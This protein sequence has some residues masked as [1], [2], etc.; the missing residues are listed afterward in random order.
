MSHR[1]DAML[2]RIAQSAQRHFRHGCWLEVQPLS[3][4]QDDATVTEYPEQSRALRAGDSL[5]VQSLRDGQPVMMRNDQNPLALRRRSDA[6][7]WITAELPLA[8]ER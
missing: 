1:T 3:I 2:L 7:G 5:R 8:A 6:D 4:A